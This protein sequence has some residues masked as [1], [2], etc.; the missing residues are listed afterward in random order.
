MGSGVGELLAKIDVGVLG[1]AM[2]DAA[3]AAGIGVTV[4]FVDTPRPVNVYISERAAQMYT[5]TEVRC[6][7]ISY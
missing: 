4:T 5:L 2:L 3:A 1:G 6:S 7:C